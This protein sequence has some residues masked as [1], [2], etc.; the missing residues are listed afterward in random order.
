MS[1]SQ[2]DKCI[3][4]NKCFHFIPSFIRWYIDYSK[5]TSTVQSTN[6]TNTI[7]AAVSIAPLYYLI[8]V[9]R[10]GANLRNAGPLVDTGI[11]RYI[12]NH[13]YIDNIA[14]HWYIDN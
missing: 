8:P 12:D 6:T 14:N 1:T 2:S 5:P 10:F 7:V 11:Y 4:L 9:D 3:D 13:W